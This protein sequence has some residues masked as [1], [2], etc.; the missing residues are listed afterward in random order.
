MCMI[1]MYFTCLHEVW[2]DVSSALAQ[3]ISPRYE[4]R[5]MGRERDSKREMGAV[6]VGGE[7]ERWRERE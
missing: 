3:E 4:I 5:Y 7:I 1:I 2:Q 6:V